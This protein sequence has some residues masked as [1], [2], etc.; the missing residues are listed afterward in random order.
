MNT[1][2]CGCAQHILGETSVKNHVHSGGKAFLKN[3]GEGPALKTPILNHFAV[4]Y[5]HIALKTVQIR[6]I[7][8]Y[9]PLDFDSQ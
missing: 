3:F 7:P 8:L 2:S 9:R 1:M 5:S 4:A 6:K